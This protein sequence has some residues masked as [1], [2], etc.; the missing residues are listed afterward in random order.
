MDSPKVDLIV[1]ARWIGYHLNISL[2]YVF[3]TEDLP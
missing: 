2:W 1:A 3:L